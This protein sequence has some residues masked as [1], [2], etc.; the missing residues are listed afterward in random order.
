MQHII[1]NCVCVLVIS[2]CL[3]AC[4]FSFVYNNLGWL[5]NW[6][7][8]D[9][10]TLNKKQQ[11]AFDTSFNELHSW[12]R[13]TQL[14]EYSR[15]LAEF[16]KQ[17]NLGITEG[18]LEEQLTRIKKHWVTARN[19]AKPQLILLAHTLSSSQRKRVIDEI[20]TIN[21][22]RID[23]RDELNENERNKVECKKQ[24]KQLKKWIGRLTNAQ[25]LEVCSIIQDVI[26]TFDHRMDYRI[27]WHLGLKKV[28]AMDLNK[29]QY[30][31]MFTELI[32]NPD[33]LKSSEYV[34]LSKNNTSIS[35]KLF[36]Y[37]MNNLTAKQL[38]R[39]NNQLDD[40]IDDLNT[41][42]MDD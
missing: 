42:E 12:H 19:K 24:T 30:E 14:K 9:Y 15:Q 26:L 22:D 18:E 4:S 41:L 34:T 38:K 35:I 23:D 39:F 33:S 20:A 21:Q 36:H 10:V 32:S 5:S 40:F 29:Q 8:D 17:V 6:Y 7:L 27:K 2:I 11:E 37:M 25:K 16:K 3:T 28:L 31:I 1:R 13:R